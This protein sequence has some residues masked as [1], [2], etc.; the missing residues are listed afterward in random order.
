MKKGTG[1]ARRLDEVSTFG[2]ALRFLIPHEWVEGDDEDDPGTYLYHAP[3]ATSGWFRASLITVKCV[4][5][6]EER[7][8]SIFR[9]ESFEVDEETN[10]YV[11][12]WERDSEEDGVAIHIYN[13]KVGNAVPPSVVREAVFSYTVLAG[14]VG[15]PETQDEVELLGKLV[16]RAQFA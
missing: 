15:D 12:R 5:S 1:V 9:G 4:A 2:G 13:W 14:T 8:Q 3:G 16:R 10:N 7:L 11:A 6:P